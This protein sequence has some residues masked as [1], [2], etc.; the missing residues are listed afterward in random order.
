MEQQRL[1]IIVEAV[2]RSQTAFRGVVTGLN[3]ARTAARQLNTEVARTSAAAQQGLNRVGTSAQGAGRGV[4]QLGGAFRGLGGLLAALSGPIRAVGTLISGLIGVFRVLGGIAGSIFGAL[5]ALLRS[6]LSVLGSV[7]RAVGGVLASAFQ[8]LAGVVGGAAKTA[9][10]GFLAGMTAIAVRGV[11]VNTTLERLTNSFSAMFQNTKRAKEFMRELRQEAI[12]SIG[13]FTDL[14][15]NAKTL[16]GFG[17]K[18]PEI[19]PTLRVLGDAAVGLAGSEG[20]AEMRDRLATIFGQIR[21]KGTLQGDEALQLAEA[22]VPVRDMLGV[23]PGQDFGDLK[24]TA[25][26]A[27]PKLLAGLNRQFGGLQAKEM[28]NV[29]GK[30][31]TLGDTLDDLSARLSEGF[32][33]R[34]K[35][36]MDLLIQFL[37][38]LQNTR[39]GGI[40][41]QALTNILNAAGDALVWLASQLQT[42]GTWLAWFIQT[43]Q[44]T[45]LLAQA[46]GWLQVLYDA[47]KAFLDLVS[48][49]RGL[50]GIWEN[51]RDAAVSAIQTVWGLWNGFTATLGYLAD[52]GDEIFAKFEEGL[53][54]VRDALDAIVGSSTVFRT[55]GFLGPLLGMLGG[56]KIVGDAVRQSGGGGGA[57]QIEWRN[58]PTTSG[59]K[60][61]TP[62]AINPRTGAEVSLDPGHF[63]DTGK[64]VGPGTLDDAIRAAGGGTAAVTSPAAR[65][66]V[67]GAWDRVKGFFGR[68]RGG[69]GAAAGAETNAAGEAAAGM[70]GG[71]GR[72]LKGGVTGAIA[73][74]AGDFLLG[75]LPQRGFWGGVRALGKGALSGYGYGTLGGLVTGAG[76]GAL[77]GGVG[78]G[79][80][81][82]LGS[83]LGGIGGALYGGG[84]GLWDYLHGGQPQGPV[85]E[86]VNAGFRGAA[87]VGRWER[88]AAGDQLSQWW[89]GLKNDPTI[90]GIGGA[91]RT[92]YGRGMG[93]PVLQRLQGLDLFGRQQQAAKA[94]QGRFNGWLAPLIEAE[95]MPPGMVLPGDS[96]GTGPEP[97]VTTYPYAGDHPIPMTPALPNY[98]PYP[99]LAQATRAA[100]GAVQSARTGGVY[101]VDG[102]FLPL[103]GLS[104]ADPY[105]GSYGMPGADFSPVPN[106]TAQPGSTPL[107][108]VINL[109]TNLQDLP[110]KAAQ[111][112]QSTLDRMV[113]GPYAAGTR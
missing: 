101:T 19:K 65:G 49:G 92:G 90:Q 5:T 94:W 56:G 3:G 66:G 59:G 70:G 9:L 89:Q 85:A 31:A 69:T 15:K 7:A 12:S 95:S 41:L 104:G 21:A 50:E 40:I 62:V 83:R 28:D 71:L 38:W 84:R 36:A 54:S 34:L 20:S 100:R 27:I 68:F 98:T 25:G 26:Q 37:G 2:N 46:A 77:F 67:L 51:F 109:D 110:S 18:R 111:A 44:G 14:S 80:G 86:T 79:P 64:Y 75:Q 4:T 61:P 81:A 22:G 107:Q 47:V 97:S 108:I 42:A 57:H 93:D 52:H 11:Q 112:L 106:M 76:I 53:Y 87:A 35:Q 105:G 17:F 32:T 29:S 88:T 10:A 73:T 6:L 78:A 102:G 33:D 48:G 1:Q 13:S 103:P 63:D 96:Y 55:L 91:W 60:I 30:A 39:E 45:K 8:R 113:R 72:F 82:A 16:L 43:G 24:L 74:L 99:Q 58:Y 23:K